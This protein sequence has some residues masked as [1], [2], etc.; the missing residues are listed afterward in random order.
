MRIFSLILFSLWLTTLV[1]GQT[2]VEGDDVIR[3]D[4]D[5]TSLLF[6]ATDKQ[7]RFITTLRAEDVRVL[8]DG[9]VQQLFAFQRETDRPLA[10]AF[11]IDVSDSE[12]RTL[13]QE[14]A[15]ARLFI[16]HVIKS[17]TDQA[18][19]IPFGGAP[20]VEQ[21]LTRNVINIYRALE[22]VEIS[23]SMYLGAGRRLT[24]IPTGPGMPAQPEDGSTAIWEALAL[25]STQIL[26]KPLDGRRRAIILLTDGWDTTSRI[27]RT[28]AIYNV[29]AA[30]AVI[31]VIGIGD[32]RQDGVNQGTL[33]E[34][35][36][37]TGGRA[38]FPKKEADLNKAF[39]EIEQELRTQYLI[40]Y[41]S[42]N[43][44]RDGS[45]RKLTIEITNPDLRKEKIQLRH[46]P[47]Y[48]ATKRN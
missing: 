30:E 23:S 21:D 38:F 28:Q 32:D 34:I 3:V 25:T 44:N 24:G 1:P 40:A 12:A 4:A 20:F 8:E 19:I 37:R 22:R 31:Y 15:A 7:R 5:V 43:K 26:G 17:R 10:L 48:F 9:T 47:G 11:L 6:T 45:Y 41:S 35:A 27:S 2:P 13:P 42:T 46:R 18:A 29:I 39:T 36:E 33:R 16:E 14:K